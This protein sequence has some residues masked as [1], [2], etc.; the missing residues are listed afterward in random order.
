MVG[1]FLVKLEVRYQRYE[2]SECPNLYRLRDMVRTNRT[3]LWDTVP[4]WTKRQV[5]RGRWSGGVTTRGCVVGRSPETSD[6]KR[7]EPTLWVSFLQ[8]TSTFSVPLVVPSETTGRVKQEGTSWRTHATEI[9]V[10]CFM[11]SPPFWSNGG[12]EATRR[13]S[14]PRCLLRSQTSE[15][16]ELVFGTKPFR[17]LQKFESWYLSQESHWVRFHWVVL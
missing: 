1:T 7:R 10:C 5:W 4:G 11:R 2:R 6:F 9:G 12:P 3:T 13:G 15:K 8:K 14:G 16:W 17:S